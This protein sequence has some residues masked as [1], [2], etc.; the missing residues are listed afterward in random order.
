MKALNKIFAALTLG[1][2]LAV[3]GL[4]Y[5]QDAAEAPAEPQVDPRAEAAANL[6]QLL[7][8]VKQGQ[9]TDAKENKAREA[10]FAQAKAD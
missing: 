6:E 10:R 7:Q 1:G 4:T 2:A 5:A 9:A 8:F 3:S